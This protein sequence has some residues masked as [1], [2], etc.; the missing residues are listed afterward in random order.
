MLAS[1]LALA[2][3]VAL[4][5]AGGG[6][7]WSSAAGARGGASVPVAPPSAT[8]RPALLPELSPAA[9]DP[10]PSALAARLGAAIDAGG[11]GPGVGAVVLDPVTGS[12]L[13]GR[14]ADVPLPPAS[15]VKLVV[16]VA[17]LEALGPQARLRT[18]T[19]LDGSTV[20][21]VGGGDP[22]F[23]GLPNLATATARA[24]GARGLR[25]VQLA[26]DL[27]RYAGDSVA[28]GW[29]PHYVAEGDVAPVVP[30]EYQEGRLSSGT[31]PLR[32]EDPADQA[33]EVFAADLRSAG[34]V[35]STAIERQASAAGDRI[36]AEVDSR[37][38]LSLVEQMLTDSDNDLAEALA[39]AVAVRLG[40]PATFLGGAT[41][42]RS[43]LVRLGLD[44]TGL[45]LA[46][47]SGLSRLDV[48]P[49]ML[50]ARLLTVIAEPGHPELRPV[51]EGLPVAGF[52]GT[53]AGRYRSGPAAAA[54]GLV[55]AKSGR[56]DGVS[57]LAGTV[58]DTSGRLLVF[59][60]LAPHAPRFELAEPAL[61]N[62]V[63]TLAGCGCRR[64]PVP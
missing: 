62:L 2:A 11:A 57:S 16:A 49:P 32:T 52:T 58:V 25:Q 23:D 10:R 12:V 53:L 37:P 24:L 43:E 35:V 60:V 6:A 54:A 63:A 9:P 38:V 46:D 47:A 3:A 21:L 50:L 42:T 1:R 13:F 48:V 19:V 29:L 5:A 18:V 45:Y 59:V 51:L 33:A 22:Q 14:N 31:G 30:L 56:L 40:D 8:E 44:P 28:A 55:R 41:A 64:A 17:A 36:L 39:R 4:A 15:T 26:V 7:T 61:D 20:I 27:S 34:L